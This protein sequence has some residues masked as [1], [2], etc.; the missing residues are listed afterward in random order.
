M[1]TSPDR[2]F[3][4]I[5]WESPEESPKRAISANSGF[6]PLQ[7]VL[8]QNTGRCASEKIEPR[9]GVDTKWYVSKYAGSRRGVDWGVSHCLGKGTSASDDVGPEGRWIVRSHIGWGGE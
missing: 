8:E 4:K 9:K 2:R 1:E 3:L 5:L 7:M 6:G